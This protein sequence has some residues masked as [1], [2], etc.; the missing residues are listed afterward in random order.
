MPA[1]SGI[2]LGRL[3]HEECLAAIEALDSDQNVHLRIHQAR[4]AI[5]RARSLIA[6]G[7][8]ELDTGTA[9]GI[10][11]RTGESLGALRDAH[12]AALTAARMDRRCPDPGWAPAAA[13]LMARA[14]RLA[15]R[16]LALDPSLARRRRAIARARRQLEA[17]PWDTLSAASI[18]RGLA[19]QA[20][21]VEKATRRSH[22][23]RSP[24][25]RHR[26]R[27]R[28]RRLRMQV[29]AL[30]GLGIRVSGHPPPAS[31]RLRRLSDALGREHDRI[32]L[33]EAL[34]RTRRLD[35][36]TELLRLLNDDGDGDAQ[37]A[38]SATVSHLP[39]RAGHGHRQRR[40]PC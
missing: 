6:L 23:D 16:E 10:L 29:D 33:V 34:R 31:A 27:R 20:Q 11:Q 7:A 38:S 21:R 25:N 39:A 14:D 40:L 13:A 35:R 8:R 36:R 3:V 30:A 32:V 12:A 28:V 22:Q 15:R 17:L 5:R 2:R 37:P 1:S 26:L 24:E 4:K 9:D 18:K 19:R